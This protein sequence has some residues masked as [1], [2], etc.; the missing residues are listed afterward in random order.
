M[1]ARLA[2]FATSAAV[3]ATALLAWELAVRFGYLRPYQFPPA[4]RIARAFVELSTTGFP[5]GVSIWSHTLVTVGRV[6]QVHER[7]ADHGVVVPA[8]APVLLAVLGP[9]LLDGLRCP[10]K[11]RCGLDLADHLVD[12]PGV[13]DPDL[14]TGW[15]AVAHRPFAAHRRTV[16]Q[17]ARATR[18]PSMRGTSR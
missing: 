4:S 3:I 14:D 2:R 12:G 10:G 16:W 7:L 9:P 5:T 15:H 17:V 8:G 11:G 6:V 1:N 13:E 18:T